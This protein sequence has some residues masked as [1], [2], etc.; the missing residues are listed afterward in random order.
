MKSRSG[1]RQAGIQ[2]QS[3]GLL[4]GIG[5]IPNLLTLSKRSAT[6]MDGASFWQQLIKMIRFHM[7]AL[8]LHWSCNPQ[9]ENAT[10]TKRER[11]IGI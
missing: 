9:S 4:H 1:F 3:N 5:S 8:G 10:L 2:Q 7:V 6:R 11:Q